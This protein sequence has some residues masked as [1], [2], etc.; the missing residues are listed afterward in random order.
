[1]PGR[2]ARRGLGALAAVLLAA[3]LPA[4]IPGSAHGR[5]VTDETAPTARQTAAPL[6]THDL[7]RRTFVVVFAGHRPHRVSDRAAA[8]NL[9]HFGVRTPAQVIRRYQPGGV[10]YFA[11]NIGTVSQVRRLSSELQS[12]A[13]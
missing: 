11:E 4:A 9:R 2:R 13:A 5:P 3:G 10:I 12:A 6:S 7:A 8:Y 1:M